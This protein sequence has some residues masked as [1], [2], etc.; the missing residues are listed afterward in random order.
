MSVNNR[1]IEILANIKRIVEC[2]NVRPET[3]VEEV[4]RELKR[5][6]IN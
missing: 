1:L 6:K 3:K 5:A 4:K 2:D